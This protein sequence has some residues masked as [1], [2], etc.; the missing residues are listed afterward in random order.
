MADTKKCAHPACSCVV[1][2]DGKYCSQYC[3]DA[4]D[5]TELS[6]NCRHAGCAL[7][8]AVGEVPAEAA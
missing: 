1:P 6:C 7:E 2:E 4:A 5:T 8:D 3:E